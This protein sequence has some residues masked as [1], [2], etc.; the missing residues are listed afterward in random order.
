MKL[1]SQYLIRES[2]G[3]DLNFINRTWLDNYRYG[4]YI[5]KSTRNSIFYP[6]Y[7]K[8][9]DRIL[10]NSTT[11]I[12]C[13]P[14]DTNVIFGFLSYEADIVHY[15]FVKE[16]FRRMGIATLLYK[17]ANCP[18]IFTHKT[19]MIEPFIDTLILMNDLK[20]NPYLLYKGVE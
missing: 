13:Y 10:Y 16:A 18:H 4:S 20:Y 2:V 5:G 7:Q 8:I 3:K 1:V 17:H 12:C 15:I 14:E 11:L 6:E 19:I 9:L